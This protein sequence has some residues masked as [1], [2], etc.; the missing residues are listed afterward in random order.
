MTKRLSLILVSVFTL[1][2]SLAG[3]CG[4]SYPSKA[5][6]LIDGFAAGGGTDYLARIIGSKLTD[7]WGQPVI[8]DNR[9]GA[10]SNVAA[11]IAARANPDGHTLFIALTSTLAPSRTLYPKLG[12]DVLNDF[13]YVTLVASG[14]YVLVV[15]PSVP[16]RTVPEL[17]AFAKS[18][19]GAIRYGSSGVAG[20]IHLA[21]ELL[22]VRAGI[23]LLHVPYKGAAPAVAAVAAGEVQMA[24][25]SV[26]AAMPLVQSN[27]LIPLAVTSA[28]RVQALPGLPT[29]AESGFPGF[30]VTPSYGILAPRKTPM[31]IV[32]ALNTEIGRILALSDV[33]AKFATQALEATASTPER[34]KAVMEAEVQ[35]WARVIYQAGIKPE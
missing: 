29:I 26:A 19:P 35:Q 20:P 17:V 12:Y 8:V 30:D 5:I 13:A 9:P 14:T 22:K 3:Q 25:S 33:Q 1:T 16:V 27:R 11:E 6:R 21:A 15:H 28:R 7:S 4:D 31:S 34:F 23:D 24:F 18:R 10:A 2:A 32:S